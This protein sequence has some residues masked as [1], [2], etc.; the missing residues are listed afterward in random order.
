LRKDEWRAMSP[1]PQSEDPLLDELT[2]LP[3]WRHFERVLLEQVGRSASTGKPV[4]LILFGVDRFDAIGEAFGDDVLRRV[5]ERLRGSVKSGAMV[6]RVGRDQ[7]ALILENV[8]NVIALKIALRVAE[9]IAAE[10]VEAGGKPFA[11]TVSAGVAT[12]AEDGRD[13]GSLLAHAGRALLARKRR[14]G[15]GACGRKEVLMDSQP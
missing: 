4:S 13:A 9:G 7:F 15:N 3:N 10:P 1:S 14:G 2:G 5:A 11:L 8:D 12:C 6:A